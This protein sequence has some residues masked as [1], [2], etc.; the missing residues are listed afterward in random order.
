MSEPTEAV[1]TY[2]A[3]V[4]AAKAKAYGALAAYR[5]HLVEAEKA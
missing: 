3:L 4:R 1:E 2:F 5:D